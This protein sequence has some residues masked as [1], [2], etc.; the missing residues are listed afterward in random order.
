MIYT[1]SFFNGCLFSS[2]RAPE[3]ILGHHYDARIDIWSVGAVLAELH[4]GYVLFQN[5]SI[6]TMLSRITGI[7][8]PFPPHVLKN[9]SESSKYFSAVSNIVY[10]RDDDGSFQL[11]FPKKTDLAS[12]LHLPNSNNSN[13]SRYNIKEDQNA[14]TGD[15]ELFLDFVRQLLHLDPLQR[16]TAQAALCHPW[17]ADA[18]TIHVSEYIIGQGRGSGGGG[19]G[20]DNNNNRTAPPPPPP[21]DHQHLYPDYDDEDDDLDDDDDEEG[22]NLYMDSASM[23]AS[24][25]LDAE[26]NAALEYLMLNNTTSSGSGGS[27]IDASMLE[28]YIRQMRLQ[29]QLQEGEDYLD[30][31]QDD[32]DDEEDNDDDFE[33]VEGD[34]D[35]DDDQDTDDAGSSR[36]TVDA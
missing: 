21:I 7:L 24:E 34:D 26:S 15:Q 23:T 19:G 2:I 22:S 16:P 3:V 14:M 28:E 8:G 31:D 12:R 20:G 11:I 4:T 17:L 36:N 25:L 1:S 33:D 6:A 32:D 10:E 18:D 13:N 27:G 5:E 9:G 30:E 35:D 29:Q